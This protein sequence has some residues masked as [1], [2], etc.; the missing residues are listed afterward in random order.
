MH[1]E[2]EGHLTRLRR[3]GGGGSG[4]VAGVAVIARDLVDRRDGARAAVACAVVP[5]PRYAPRY[6][7]PREGRA[8]KPAAPGAGPVVEPGAPRYQRALAGAVGALV[9]LGVAGPPVVRQRLP[10]R[11]AAAPFSDGSIIRQRAA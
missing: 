8:V 6:A 2:V 4:G 10:A 9:V 7:C 1:R 3:G 11:R 5:A